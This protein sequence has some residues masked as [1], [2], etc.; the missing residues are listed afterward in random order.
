MKI[1]A[2]HSWTLSIPRAK[3][4]QDELREEVRFRPLSLARVRHVAGADMAIDAASGRVFAAVVV[5]NFP[6]L[7]IVETRVVERALA[8]PYVPGYLS[9]REAP[10]V[11]ACLRA[12]R[13]P[14]DV[15]LCDGQGIAHPRGFGLASH[16]GLWIGIPTVGSAKSRLVGT[17]LP[18]KAKR[19]SWTG[20]YVE[21]ERVGSVLRTRDGINP[22]YVSP[23][24]LIDHASCRRIVL[25]CATRYRLPEP[26]R[27]A[28][29]LAGEAKRG[30][31][32]PGGEGA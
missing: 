5:M 30:A 25:A 9:F 7:D 13:T 23:G 15:L 6:D 19:G 20:L 2:L 24:H 22:L 11:L 3:A 14:I 17:H 18:V 16:I 29:I 12:T 8:F 27:Q 31:A 10:V 1:P 21:G 32:P 4:L 26:Q 28:D